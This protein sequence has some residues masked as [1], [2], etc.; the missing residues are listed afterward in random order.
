MFGPPASFYVYRCYG[1]H[2]LLNV[3]TGPVDYPDAVLLRGVEGIVGPGRLTKAIWINGDLNGKMANEETGL[4]FSEGTR[5]SRTQI[6]RSPRIGVD[7]A[8]EEWSSK[9][10]RFS[11]KTE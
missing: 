7:Y 6:I 10:Y 1:L 5:P 2:W 4:W 9:P 3:V 11:L 8:G